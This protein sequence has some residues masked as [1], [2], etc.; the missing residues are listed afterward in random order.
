MTVFSHL[1]QIPLIDV[2]AIFIS[3]LSVGFLVFPTLI[4]TF[5]KNLNNETYFQKNI[6]K[7]KSR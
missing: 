7:N 3:G 4:K 5:S 2:A 1:I 6:K